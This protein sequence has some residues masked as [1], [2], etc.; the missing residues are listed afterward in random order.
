MSLRKLA[1]AGTA[2]TAMMAS[3]ATASVIDR[4]FFQV[5]GVV[6]VWGADG[7]DDGSGDQAP[8]VSDFVV[9]LGPAGGTDLIGGTLADGFTVLT[10][11][12]TPISATAG[13]IDAATFDPITGQVNGGVFTDA[14]TT[15]V[16]DVADSLTAFEIDDTTDVDGI[17][18]TS[19]E[20]SFYVASNTNL[21]FVHHVQ[22]RLLQ[23]T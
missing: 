16:L 23:A 8:I 14:G 15:G 3:T 13:G 6:V 4:P 18:N 1:I 10:G 11:S 22:L 7:F 2:L 19:H 9:G 5:L 20:S 21:K 17:G 12:L